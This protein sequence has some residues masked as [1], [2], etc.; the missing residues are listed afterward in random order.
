MSTL[1]A[2]GDLGGLDRLAADLSS[3]EWNRKCAGI[4]AADELDVGYR[5]VVCD[6]PQ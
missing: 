1:A 3:G 2:G 4:L 6:V 5:L